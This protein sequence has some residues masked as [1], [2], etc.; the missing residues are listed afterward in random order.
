M[1]GCRGTHE[2]GGGPKYSPSLYNTVLG[3][4]FG[5]RGLG[6][7]ACTSRYTRIYGT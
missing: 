2:K 4:G 5:V 3:F 1:R 6:F 7:R